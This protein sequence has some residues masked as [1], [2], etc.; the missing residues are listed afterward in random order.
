M[1]RWSESR[2]NVG[3]EESI[4]FDAE[5]LGVGRPVEECS[6]RIACGRIPECVPLSRAMGGL[7]WVRDDR[8][9]IW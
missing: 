9:L 2:N 3:G 4:I 1:R 6:Q 5:V 7:G 8:G